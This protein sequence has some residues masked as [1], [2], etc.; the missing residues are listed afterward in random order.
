MSLKR[1]RTRGWH[2]ESAAL[3]ERLSTLQMLIAFWPAVNVGAD[4]LT[5]LMVLLISGRGLA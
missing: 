4:L 3:P 5:L 1:Q 2:L